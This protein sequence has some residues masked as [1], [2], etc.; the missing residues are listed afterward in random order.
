MKQRARIKLYTPHAGQKPLHASNARFRIATCGRRWGKTFAC[1]NEIAKFAWEN[2]GTISWWVAP[3]Y[4][5]SRIAWR[6][7]T[8]R[9]K[10]AIAEINRSEMIVTWKSGSLTFFKSTT[11]FDSLRGEG[12]SFMIVDEAAFVPEEAWNE[13]LRPTLSDNMGRAIIVSTPK[14][15]NWF[16]RMWARGQDPSESAYESWKFPTSSNPYIHPDEI[17]EA[18][19]TLPMDI[20]RQEYLAEFLEDSSGVFRGVRKCAIGSFREPASERRYVVGWDVAKYVDWSVI[21][22][23]DIDTKEVVAFDRFNQID[24]DTQVSRVAEMAVRY[25]WAE[26]IYDG[27]GIGEPLQRD[28]RKYTEEKYGRTLQITPFKFTSQS[29]MQLIQLLAVKIEQQ[30]I[31]Y[32]EIDVLINELQAFTY[33]LMPSGY[34]KYEAPPGSHDD[35]V[36]AL[37]LATWGAYNNMPLQIFV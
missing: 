4:Q 34:I 23:M 7:L 25:N 33:T 1:I 16:F 2:P 10:D 22:V 12:V 29:K 27:T 32:P 18:K 37:A 17:E 26:I 15:H 20:F 13:S 24:W 28:L 31:I 35:C 14:G 36:M 8:T 6:I 9:F 21:F 30:G 3:T 11:N 5:Q 19:R